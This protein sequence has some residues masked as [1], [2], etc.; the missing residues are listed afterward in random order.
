MSSTWVSF[1]WL[2]K[3]C[4]SVVCPVWQF[5]F[6]SLRANK[7]RHILDKERRSSVVPFL[8]KW[9]IKTKPKAV[10]HFRCRATVMLQ[11]SC[12]WTHKSI[13]SLCFSVHALRTIWSLSL[14]QFNWIDWSLR[15]F[16]LDLTIVLFLVFSG[17]LCSTAVFFCSVSLFFVLPLALYKMQVV[18]SLIPR[19]LP[20]IEH[21]PNHLHTSIQLSPWLP[22][23][24]IPAAASLLAPVWAR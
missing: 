17:K 10:T 1:R 20:F 4:P 23:V 12:A 15:A 18:S 2:F 9:K 13:P 19:W 21:K 6:V 16:V 8:K 5:V 3:P 14:K 7:P 24:Q 22:G 11:T